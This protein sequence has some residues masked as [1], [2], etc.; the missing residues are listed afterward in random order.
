MTATERPLRQIA[1]DID[2]FGVGAME[3]AIAAIAVRARQ[4]DICPIVVQVLADPTEP[5][6]ARARA[7]G[8]VA[9]HLA[10]VDRVAASA[11]VRRA[12]AATGRSRPRALAE[13]DDRTPARCAG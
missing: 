8:I 13:V 10:G 11:L 5:D 3:T 2:R 4:A 7:F 12:T 9:T 6:I 1:A